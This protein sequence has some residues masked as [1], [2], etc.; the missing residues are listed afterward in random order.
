[1]TIPTSTTIP[2]GPIQ[3]SL[4]EYVELPNDGKCYQ[5]I[6]GDLFV[7]PAPIPRHQRISKKLQM[8]LIRA[9]EEEGKGEVYNAPI[10]VI[11]GRHNIV[12]PDLLFIRTERLK[13]IGPKNIVG[14]PDLIVEIL[15]SSTRRTDVLV[16]S[17]TYAK[18]GV[19][20]YWVVDPDL[21]RIEF[22]RLE[23]GRYVLSCVASS[24]EVIAPPD[25][26]QVRISL[27]DVFG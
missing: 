3:L 18:F 21:D 22:F 15:S 11:L 10:D 16:K 4:D 13:I 5:I 1:M 12:Q 7:N 20:F 14:P 9:L 23:G 27:Q 25:F 17:K 8:T 26:P 24:P 19:T 6:N 2:A